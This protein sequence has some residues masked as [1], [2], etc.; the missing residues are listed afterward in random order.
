M[1]INPLV[2]TVNCWELGKPAKSRQDA[3]HVSGQA[4]ATREKAAEEARVRGAF[5]YNLNFFGFARDSTLRGSIYRQ[6][7]LNRFEGVESFWGVWF[8]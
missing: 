6:P 5:E 2:T 8:R 7:S 4:G 1:L 3:L